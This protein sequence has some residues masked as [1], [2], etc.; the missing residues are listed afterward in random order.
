MSNITASFCGRFG[1][2]RSVACKRE[3]HYQVSGSKSS[4]IG[5]NVSK[6][7]CLFGTYNVNFDAIGNVCN[8]LTM[9][10]L[11]QKDAE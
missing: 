11:H 8:V 2:S 4:R 3:D 6:I 7:S 9:K 10:V 5:S 1:I